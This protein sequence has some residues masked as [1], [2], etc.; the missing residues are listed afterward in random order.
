[1]AYDDAGHLTS[2]T[3]ARGQAVAFSYDDLGR[4]TG[5]YQDSLQGP[6]RASWTYD[7]VKKV[8]VR[9]VHLRDECAE[10]LRRNV[11]LGASAG[12]KRFE[13][14]G[15]ERAH[16]SAHGGAT[17]RGRHA[18]LRH[19]WS[20]AKV[21]RVGISSTT[22]TFTCGGW[23]TTQTTASAMSSAVSGRVLA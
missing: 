13:V 18:G 4:K 20:A 9:E 15:V 17:C 19:T 14:Q 1:M 12:S 22:L 21:C 3:D 2:T 7:T 10:V 16:R 5:E 6:L 11:P 8:G 23:A